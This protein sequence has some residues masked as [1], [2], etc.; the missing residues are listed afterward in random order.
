M[1]GNLPPPTAWD[2]WWTMSIATLSCESYVS[3]LEN[4]ISSDGGCSNTILS[5][6]NNCS[7]SLREELSISLPLTS[8]KLHSISSDVHREQLQ[9]S[10]IC[11]LHHSN[12]GLHA[13]LFDRYL[14]IAKWDSLDIFQDVRHWQKRVVSVSV[15]LFPAVPLIVISRPH[16]DYVVYNFQ[17]FAGARPWALSSPC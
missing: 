6:I 15:V 11:I 1:R 8:S 13:T 7:G 3:D 17:S 14:T 10:D 5:I 4:T 9:R 16:R 2:Y 12:P